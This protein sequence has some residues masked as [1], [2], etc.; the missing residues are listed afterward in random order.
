MEASYM[1]N[2]SHHNSARPA[3]PSSRDDENNSQKARLSR[4]LKTARDFGV[5]L[6]DLALWLRAPETLD[7][8]RLRPLLSLAAGLPEAIYIADLYDG[9]PEVVAMLDDA[10][11]SIRPDTW[12]VDWKDLM[13]AADREVRGPTF[14]HA[15]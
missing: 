14:A 3:G 7:E 1:G 6:A 4:L 15:A 12:A 13:D 2:Y 9:D 8:D 11:D 10:A 5:G